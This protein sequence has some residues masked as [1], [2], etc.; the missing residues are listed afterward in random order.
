MQQTMTRPS[1]PVFVEQRRRRLQHHYE[2]KDIENASTPDWA[3]GCANCCYGIL[4]VPGTKEAPSANVAAAPLYL[5]RTFQ[6]VN[7]R[8]E[9]CTCS[10]GQ[11]YRRYLRGAY[12]AVQ[13]GSDH[14]PEASREILHDAVT[15]PT[16]HFEVSK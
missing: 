9:F 3:H 1:V 12:V 2:G 14:L 8:I 11:A 16:F 10:A 13:D 6:A 4:K 7:Q 5:V 15:M